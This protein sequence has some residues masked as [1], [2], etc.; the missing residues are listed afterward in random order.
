VPFE[1]R[2]S[3]YEAAMATMALATFSVSNLNSIS[4]SAQAK[5]SK[6]DNSLC[7]KKSSIDEK[8]YLDYL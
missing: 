2:P 7:I 8:Q 3:P 4:I 1:T 5:G 6:I